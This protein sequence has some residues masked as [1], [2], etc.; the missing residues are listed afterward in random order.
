MALTKI[1]SKSTT[2]WMTHIYLYIYH[3]LN[4]STVSIEKCCQYFTIIASLFRYCLTEKY[5]RN[6]FEDE[7]SPFGIFSK[8]GASFIIIIYLITL[9]IIILV[10]RIHPSGQNPK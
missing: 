1:L 5:I 7:Q 2:N 6:S 10:C 3:S 8:A 9:F 4:L